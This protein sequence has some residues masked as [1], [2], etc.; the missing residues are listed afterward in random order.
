MITPDITK[1]NPKINPVVA[2]M[3]TPSLGGRQ[4]QHLRVMMG[5]GS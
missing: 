4:K 5:R 3:K 2:V 1:V